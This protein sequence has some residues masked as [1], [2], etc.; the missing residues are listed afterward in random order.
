MRQRFISPTLVFLALAGI[1]G[2]ASETVTPPL[3]DIVVPDAQRLVRHWNASI[4][5]QAWQDRCAAPLRA[6]LAQE[7]PK[8][9]EQL[10]CDPLAVIAASASCRLVVTAVGAGEGREVAYQLQ[11]DLGTQSEAVFAAIARHGVR[12]DAAG[13]DG[14]VLI[15]GDDSH[16]VRVVRKGGWLLLSPAAEAVPTP[17]PSNGTSD[18][19]FSFAGPALADRLMASQ[20]L[21]VDAKAI[22]P[23][24]EPLLRRFLP[25]IAGSGDLVANGM[26]TQAEIVATWP[27]LGRLDPLVLARLPGGALDVTAIAVDG[28][29]L[30]QQVGRPVMAL[31]A[32]ESPGI[33]PD[34]MLA[35][36]GASAT[37]EELIQGMSGTWVV[38]QTPGMP[39]PGYTVIA[40]R[41]AA[42]DQVVEALVRKGGGDLPAEGDSL[43]V[44]LPKGVPLMITL[45]RDR[46]HWLVTTDQVQA[47]AWLGTQD[48][49]FASPL[50]K[51]AQDR[52]AGGACLVSVSDTAAQMRSAASVMGMVLSGIKQLAPA[53][54]Q[55]VSALVIKLA[56]LAQ[57]S[58]SVMRQSEDRLL[59]TGEGLTSGGNVG[60]IAVIAAIAIPNLLESRIAAN[61]AAAAVTLKSG[62]FPAQVQFQAGAYLDSDGNGVGEYSGDLREMAGGIPAGSPLEVKLQLLDQRFNG[63][64]PVR[65]GG[66]RYATHA[67]GEGGFVAYAWPVDRDQ[68]RRCFAITTAGAVTA[69]PWVAGEQGLERFSLWNGTA[70]TDP[71]TPPANGW[72]PYRR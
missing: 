56:A 35:D 29:P 62:I 4:F 22:S 52:M 43:P 34:Q 10:G 70:V 17:L 53:E 1:A 66:Y 38:A 60:V 54:K 7:M 14:A 55:A 50:G 69:R 58:W 49:W 19:H 12:E 40:P 13:A 18:V 39:M 23:E 61:E 31:L 42:L 25:A 57:P 26:A 65:V 3:L 59:F 27:W 71:A 32:Q 45:A 44:I 68:G 47:S 72:K 11:A 16:R 51:L 41:S 9:I 37:W 21:R 6:R 48:G 15:G 30:W 24:A 46:G 67:F 20:R 2:S 36:L 64:P 5:G 63:E 33:K 28:Q 8:L